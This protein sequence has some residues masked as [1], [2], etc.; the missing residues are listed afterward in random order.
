MCGCL[1]LPSWLSY[2]PMSSVCHP[3]PPSATLTTPRGLLGAYMLYYAICASY[4]FLHSIS[5]RFF[6]VIGWWIFLNLS[7]C[8][9][10]S[11]VSLSSPSATLC[12]VSFVPGALH[13]VFCLYA[14]T[15]VSAPFS[16]WPYFRVRQWFLLRLSIRLLYARVRRFPPC[17]TLLRHSGLLGSYMPLYDYGLY[18]CFPIYIPM[19]VFP[20]SFLCN[21][22][23]PSYL[24]WCVVCHP[25]PPYWASLAAWADLVIFL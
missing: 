5:H 3:L 14:P 4:V 15:S 2:L 25:L 13:A 1:L 20:S 16:L 8:F 6:S 19:C 21:F 24:S 9:L 11:L 7:G 17:A 10:L 12:S 22:L 23:A 18:T